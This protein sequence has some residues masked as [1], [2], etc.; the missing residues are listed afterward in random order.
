[1]RKMFDILSVLGWVWCAAVFVFLAFKSRRMS[2][3]TQSED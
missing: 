2:R 3:G 1:M